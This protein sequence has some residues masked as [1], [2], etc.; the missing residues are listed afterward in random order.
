[1]AA[2]LCLSISLSVTCRNIL[3]HGFVSA[4][5][6]VVRI[7]IALKNSSLSAMFDPANLGSNAKHDK[8]YTTENDYC[9]RW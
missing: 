9:L 1:M 5:K 7:F 6:K 3:R 8:H 2:E 4:P